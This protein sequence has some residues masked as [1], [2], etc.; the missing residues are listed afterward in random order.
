MH[1]QFRS[2]LLTPFTL[3]AARYRNTCL[4][5]FVNIPKFASHRSHI[6]SYNLYQ[7]IYILI[8]FGWMLYWCTGWKPA[9]FLNICQLSLLCF[10]WKVGGIFNFA[11][12]WTILLLVQYLVAVQCYMFDFWYPEYNFIGFSYFEGLDNAI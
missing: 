6:C 7:S 11:S 8:W 4:P 9:G 5:N 2:I 12:E 10:V 3:A 1:L